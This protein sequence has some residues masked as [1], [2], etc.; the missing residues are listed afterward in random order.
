MCPI[1]RAEIVPVMA[2]QCFIQDLEAALERIRNSDPVLR[3]MV[4]ALK[5]SKE[6]Y[7]IFKSDQMTESWDMKDGEQ[8]VD[9]NPTLDIQYPGEHMCGDPT[10]GLVHEL[11]HKYQIDKNRS[12]GFPREQWLNRTADA[13]TNSIPNSEI[14]AVVAEN[15]YRS[16]ASPRLCLR[17][18]Y[19]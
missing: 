12:A 14:D 19:G 7:L 15:R 18:N 5:A 13:S 16:K 9:W 17:W 4:D 8:H 1:A 11:W 2:D 3:E 10:A 6:P